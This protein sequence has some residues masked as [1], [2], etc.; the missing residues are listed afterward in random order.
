MRT[1]FAAIIAAGLF[2]TAA[3]ANTFE[4]S[5]SNESVK[6]DVSLSQQTYF[7]DV[8]GMY[9]TDDGSYG[10]VGAHIEDIE[11]SKD[12][13]L[14]I[15]LGVRFIAVDADA[16]GDDTGVA[17]GLGGFYRYTFPKANRFSLYGSLY[18]SPEV[19]S[20]E[21]VE[22]LWQ[23]EVRGE[24]KTLKNARVFLRYGQTSVEFDNRNDAV[25][26]NQ[27][28]GLGVVADF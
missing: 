3:N 1:K 9:H 10:Y 18:Y 21:N 26:M 8:G 14:Q 20:F 23:G 22:N 6:V 5:L 11:T 2:A 17:V 16:G 13:P 28:I 12:Y 27:G 4:G 7:L 24:Y 19:L 25:D 15:G